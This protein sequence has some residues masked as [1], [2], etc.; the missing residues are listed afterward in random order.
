MADGQDG[1]AYNGYFESKV[2]KL[3]NRC[4]S[5]TSRL[6]LS[7]IMIVPEKIAKAKSTNA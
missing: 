1:S 6:F 2:N 3:T 7:V 4:L 5:R